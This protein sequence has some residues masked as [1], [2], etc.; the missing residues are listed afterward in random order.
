MSRSKRFRANIILWGLQKQLSTL[1]VRTKFADLGLSAFVRGNVLWEG[2]HVRLILTAND[3]KGVTKAL[4]SK[5]SA[6]LRKI[7][8]RCVLDE[9]PKNFSNSSKVH[10][11]C[12][13]RFQSLACQDTSSNECNEVSEMNLDLELVSNKV[14]ALGKHERRLIHGIFLVCVVSESRRR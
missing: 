8:C 9:E 10:I 13:N 6:S 11:E 1:E 14:K 5:V 4:V 7:G 3:S 2:D 12:V